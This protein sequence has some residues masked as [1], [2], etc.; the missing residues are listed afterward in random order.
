VDARL[1][2]STNKIEQADA[3]QRDARSIASYRAS[4]AVRIA[5]RIENEAARRTVARAEVGEFSGL[6]SDEAEALAGA[7]LLRQCS[8][9][10]N[11]WHAAGL[12]NKFGESFD[13]AGV[14][15]SCNVRLCPDWMN[16]RQKDSRQ[17]AREGVARVRPEANER[18]FLVTLTSPT[19]PARRLSLLQ[20]IIVINFAWHL[21]TKDGTWQSF[22]RASIKGIEFTL[23]DQR[24]EQHR[25]E[26][27]HPKARECRECEECREWD[28][29]R[30][31]Y[32]VH[33]HLLAASRGMVDVMRLRREWTACLLKAWEA[34]DIEGGINTRD[35]LAVC[36]SRYVTDRKTKATGAVISRDAAIF[37][38]AKYITKAES[39][40]TIPAE[41]LLEVAGVR[42]WPRMFEVL[43]ECRH[44]A[45]RDA[46]AAG[47]EGDYLDTHALSSSD[48]SS[49]ED[50]CKRDAKEALR[51]AWPRAIPL[52]RL[53]VELLMRGEWEKLETMIAARVADVRSFRRASLA[54]RYPLAKFESFDG[55]TWSA[56]VAVE[57][58]EVEE[59][60]AIEAEGWRAD[61]ML[62]GRRG[63]RA[64]WQQAAAKNE[65][66]EWENYTSGNLLVSDGRRARWEYVADS[67]NDDRAARREMRDRYKE[68]ELIRA[69]LFSRGRQSEWLEWAANPTGARWVA[70][71][72][73]GSIELKTNKPKSEYTEI[74]HT[75]AARLLC[76]RQ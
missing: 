21:F 74:A 46:G 61:M 31:G 53:A 33:I 72:R 22:S 50:E 30:D 55:R 62:R 12:T 67:D 23:G 41:Q 56:A 2:T 44:N 66:R 48:L 71:Y 9:D 43:G 4:A 40:L 49:A 70:D 13:G 27:K 32:H 73:T 51:A 8:H 17:R 69:L 76:I 15:Y 24:C 65:D 47:A 45:K 10:G 14:L 68:M 57:D 42:R 75:V 6:C 20:T 19:I 58:V 11:V 29:E 63:E 3:P 54:G 59:A 25:R 38:V 18:W 34:H 16:G 39:F 36:H 60:E 35:G 64:E 5:E 37:E 52:R 7:K 26:N 28:A 1:Q